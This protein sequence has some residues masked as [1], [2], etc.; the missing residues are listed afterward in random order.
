M[1]KLDTT[2]G[3]P[4]L[5][6]YGLIARP[7]WWSGE[8]VISAEAVI[9]LLD[10]IDPGAE[11]ILRINSEGGDVF[12]GIAIYQALARR[13]ARLEVH[14]DALAASIASVIAM[15][16]DEIVMAGNAMLM[17][18]QAWTFAQG[19]GDELAKTAETLRQVDG[20]IV[21]TYA[22]RVGKQ[23][24]REQIEAWMQ[25]ETWMGAT[26]AIER[27]FADRAADLKTGATA[28]VRA[29]RFKNCPAELLQSA[30]P[31]S[32]GEVTPPPPAAGESR[33]AP[34]RHTA[35]IAARIAAA[36]LRFSKTASR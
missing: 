32:G 25:A 11:L 8:D 20:V 28:S 34:A 1:L 15:A 24:T 21:D 3:T 10:Q 36:R 27:G 2:G 19:N 22:A 9:Q 13:E 31:G 29:G 4:E 33:R 30:P 5:Y 26:D 7:S 35:T 14:V 12:E 17:I 18:H 23:S 6:L 16:G